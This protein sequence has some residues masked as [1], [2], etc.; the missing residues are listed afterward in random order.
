MKYHLNANR[1]AQFGILLRTSVAGL[2]LIA[3]AQPAMAQNASDADSGIEEI[4]VTAQ[5]RTENL[6]DVPISITVVGTEELKQ[7]NITNVED[8]Q[9]GT[10]NV[11]TYSDDSFNTNIIIRGIGSASRNIGFESAL[12]A[13][14]D[15]VYQGRNDTL[16]QDLG[17]AER[18]EVLRGPQGTL[19]GKNTTSGA[20]SITTKQ[21]TNDFEGSL[22]GDYGNY[23]AYRLSG[24][25]SGP[26]VT[27]K[28]FAKL[29]GYRSKAD[30]YTRNVSGKGPK[31]LNGENSYGARGA[32]RIKASDTFEFVVRGDI[33]I[34]KE[35]GTGDGEVFAVISN[36][37]DLDPNNNLPNVPDLGIPDDS[38]VPGNRTISIDGDSAI[39]TR[40]AGI[41]GTADWTI[42]DHTLT[43]ITAYR[44]LGAKY[45]GQDGDLTSFDYINQDFTDTSKQF[46]QE[47]RLASPNNGRFK[48]IIG[49]Y[50][51]RQT[52]NSLRDTKL[53]KDYIPLLQA[54]Y[55]IPDADITSDRISTNTQVKTKSIA[56]FVNAS[57]DITSNISLIG[58]LRVTRETKDLAVSQAVPKYIGFASVF[59]PGG[60]LYLNLARTTD[61]LS[62]TEVSPTLGLQ[63]KVGERANIYARYS[64]GF[65]SGG[66]NAELLAPNTPKTPINPDYFDVTKIRFKPESV[67]NYEVGFKGDI[68]DR[69]LRISA[70]GFYTDYKDIQISRFVGGLKG[71]EIANPSARIK[72]VELE[73][74]ALPTDGLTLSANMGYTDG[75]YRQSG[76]CGASCTN[77]TRLNVP[78]WTLGA[79]VGYE[80]KILENGTL[81]F[82]ID[83]A[84]RGTD[85]GSGELASSPDPTISTRANTKLPGFS[86]VDGRIALGLD[87]GFEVA[88]WGKNLFN[89]TYLT[90]RQIESNNALFGILH[91]AR[92]FGAPR[93]YG[94]S[95]SY[96]F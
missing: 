69:R 50:F 57:F 74:T 5:K 30:G 66:W 72:G 2:S 92:S 91:D 89:K 68:L 15:G 33:S 41:S 77:G 3:A 17:D 85:S 35:N 87:G 32:L 88:L 39:R 19:F 43:S 31:L 4:I 70:A 58:G 86:I 79:G 21:P 55:G 13:Y 93:T 34:G 8:I 45:F 75:K 78:R 73:L 49:A 28:V 9:F 42:G 36:P 84:Y 76:T 60:P 95:A 47:I 12:G 37:I 29:S 80:K 56:G 62:Q 52:S 51:Y 16:F 14:I 23:N 90:G 11:L 6:R 96:E 63:F 94:I 25:V 82:R 22:R 44:T 83:Y 81:S 61:R 20:I 26:I 67:S 18:V 65:K 59:N 46:S 7:R 48:Y 71:Y 54:V 10:P 53:G 40:I 64:K 38:L 24:N 27:D 1:A